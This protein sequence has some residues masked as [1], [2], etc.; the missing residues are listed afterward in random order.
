MISP[1]ELLE[2]ADKSFYK[3]VS[4]HLKGESLFPF[5]I[6]SNKQPAG[7]NYSQLK[8]DLVPLYEGS[9]AV[10]GKGYTVDWKEKKINGVTQSLP[11]KIYFDT[12]E[13]YL[14]FIR[15]STDFIKIE[16]SKAC[17]VEAFPALNNWVAQHPALLLEYSGVWNDLIRVCR[18]F[19]ANPPPHSFYLRELL[20]DVHT[21]FIENHV[22]ILRKLLDQLLPQEWINLSESDF[23]SRYGL[24]RPSVYTQIR[25]LD[26]KLKAYL[27][28]DECSLTLDDAAW[29]QWTPKNVFLIENQ[30]C[31]LTFPKVNDSVAIFGEGFKSRLSKYLPWLEKCH[32]YCW[33][34]LDAAGFEMVNMI[35]EHYPNAKTL[36]MD[37]GTYTAFN[38][39]AVEKRD[40]KKVLPHLTPE[41]KEL[42]KFL[43][44]HSKRLEQE[45][46]SQPYILASLE[47]KKDL[48]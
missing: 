24:K 20:I 21:K 14:H 17:I 37:Q 38:Q 9:K 12:L 6:P 48:L 47:N 27:G 30:I 11:A 32:L 19:V 43:V 22:T 46:I 40:R 5:V 4:A 41:E 35:R 36:L 2:K 8:N 16:K 29:L 23:V 1:E 3:V 44:E 26:D 31:F 25:I 39:F 18:Y 42:Y 33:F 34:D 7:T 13:D 28:Y 10:K 15:R 45:R